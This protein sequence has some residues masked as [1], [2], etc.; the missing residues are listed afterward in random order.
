MSEFTLE[1]L[2]IIVLVIVAF[3]LFATILLG[4][5][6]GIDFWYVDCKGD[7]GGELVAGKGYANP[8]C[9]ILSEKD[10]ATCEVTTYGNITK[11]NEN[12]TVCVWQSRETIGGRNVTCFLNERL[13]CE[14]FNQKTTPKCQDVPDCMPVSALQS[15]VQKLKPS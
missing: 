15:I 13:N 12:M 2:A 1:K 3:I 7:M 6:V 5:K 9:D 10:N 11:E 14:D 8:V 4:F